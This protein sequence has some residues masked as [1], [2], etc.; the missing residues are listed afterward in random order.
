VEARKGG[1]RTYKVLVDWPLMEIL[2]LLA[3]G[4]LPPLPQ[5]FMMMDG[6]TGTAR[7]SSKIKAS[8]SLTHGKNTGHTTA[9]LPVLTR[10]HFLHL[11][12]P[13]LRHSRVNRAWLF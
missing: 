13:V 4:S 9:L 7:R 2:C 8:A 3:F 11:A 1:A 12:I 6:H 10:G 5:L